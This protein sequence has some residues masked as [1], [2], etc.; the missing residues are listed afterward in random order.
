MTIGGY[1]SAKFRISFVN[2]LDNLV[3]CLSELSNTVDRNRKKST[4]GRNEVIFH[5]IISLCC[6]ALII[7]KQVLSWAKYYLC[8]K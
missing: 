3:S 2:F 7:V 6:V 4:S 1:L 8:G 5:M